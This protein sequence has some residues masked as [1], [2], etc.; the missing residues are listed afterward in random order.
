[1]RILFFITLLLMPLR[2]FACDCIAPTGDYDQEI[3]DKSFMI[4]RFKVIDLP[5]LKQPDSKVVVTLLAQDLYKG[6]EKIIANVKNI[7]VM[8]DYSDGCSRYIQQ[9]EVYDLPLVADDSSE[10]LKI[11]GQCHELSVGGWN[12]LKARNKVSDATR[13]GHIFSQ[14]DYQK[15]EIGYDVFQ[16]WY[17]DE[18]TVVLDLRNVGAYNHSH[19]KGAL[20]LGAD[21]DESRLAEI[22]PNKD[23]R[24]IVYCS[25]SLMATRMLSLTHTSLPQLHALGYENAYMLGPIWQNARDKSGNL[26]DDASSILPMTPLKD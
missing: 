25:N 2:A 5:D 19:I 26:I 12:D 6:D 17:N 11:A 9:G 23:T 4:G 3:I 20:H 14:F 13:I 15:Y 22:V 7:Q 1:M 16:E 8:Y 18:N 21:I 24:I 10:R